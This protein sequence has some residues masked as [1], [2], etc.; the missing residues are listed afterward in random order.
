LD[1]HDADAPSEARAPDDDGRRRNRAGG[2]RAPARAVPFLAALE[3]EE[4]R[5]L[6]EVSAAFAPPRRI[7]ALSDA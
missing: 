2:G 5:M 7:E 6:A 3:G 1:R 4:E